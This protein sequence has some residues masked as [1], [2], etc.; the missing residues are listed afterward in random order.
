ME[1]EGTIGSEIAAEV[2]E[3]EVRMEPWRLSNDLLADRSKKW[4][5]T[6]SF[7][8]GDDIPARFSE[9]FKLN[10]PKDSLGEASSAALVLE[11]WYS[12]A[13]KRSALKI[14]SEGIYIKLLVSNGVE[15]TSRKLGRQHKLDLS[16]PAGETNR[17]RF[18]FSSYGLGPGDTFEF[19]LGLLREAYALEFPE[20]STQTAEPIRE[21]QQS[22]NMGQQQPVIVREPPTGLQKHTTVQ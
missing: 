3:N 5:P 12:K 6:K 15:S 14:G 1:L 20:V 7:W 17:Q 2:H 21:S 16:K 9:T 19:T 18:G 22:Q 13:R 10:P 11:G 4:A 8:P